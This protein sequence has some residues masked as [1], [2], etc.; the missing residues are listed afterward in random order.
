MAIC[1]LSAP[2]IVFRL[3]GDDG[4]IIKSIDDK[5]T[6]NLDTFIQVMKNI[7]DYSRVPC[8]YYSIGDVHT[9]LGSII[10]IDKHW[11]SFRLAVRNDK[12]GLWD[13]TDLGNDLPLVPSA[14]KTKRI[15]E[16]H[17]SI[18][19][20]KSLIRCIV[21]VSFRTPCRIDGF[22]Y[23]HKQGSGIILDKEQGLVVVSCGIIPN[24]LGDV[25]VTVADSIVIP[26]KVLV[27]WYTK[28]RCLYT[29]V[30]YSF[31]IQCTITALSNMIQKL[32]VT[33]TS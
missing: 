13:Y 14:P 18:G 22:P 10:Y 19:P 16:L 12:T 24:S 21:K 7:P 33:L 6:P 3:D 4:W 25:T 28:R 9:I 27:S 5:E 2:I 1:I 8:V 23:S 29:D 11:G 31:C 30:N 26:A 32:W 17:S 20:A 15:T